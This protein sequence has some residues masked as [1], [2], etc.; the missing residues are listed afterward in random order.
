M[1]RENVKLICSS[2]DLLIDET[3]STPISIFHDFY[4]SWPRV[5]RRGECKMDL[6][7]TTTVLPYRVREPE[8]DGRERADEVELVPRA[9]AEI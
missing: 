5:T 7:K 8:E 4:E 9:K 3:N 2:F 1:R 6:E